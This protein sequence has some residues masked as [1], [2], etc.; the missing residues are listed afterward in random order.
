MTTYVY[1]FVGLAALFLGFG[2]LP[3]EAKKFLFQTYSFHFIFIAVAIWFWTLLPKSPIRKNIRPHLP[4][5][6]L[7]LFLI[8]IIF[9]IS[10][11]HLR[12]LY[13]ETNLLGV[14]QAMLEQHACYIPTQAIF[15]NQN[16]PFIAPEWGIRPFAFPFFLYLIHLINGY[17]L[18]NVYVL[19]A[20]AG[21]FALFLFY[22]L[23]QNFFSKTLSM[24]GMGLLA[25]YP[26]FVLW[27]TS[28]GFE[29][30]NLTLALL[31]F[32]QLYHLLT[33][34]KPY[35]ATR[36]F[37]TLVLLAQMRYEAA[38]FLLAILPFAIYHTIKHP[39]SRPHTIIIITPL[40]LLP[41][42]WQRTL[43]SGDYAF[44]VTEGETMFGLHHF[45]TNLQHAYSFFSGTQSEYGTLPFLFYLTL[46]GILIG[47]IHLIQNRTHITHTTHLMILIASLACV[48]Q[49]G[50]ILGYILG[51]LTRPFS[52][53]LGI[54]FLPFLITPIIY[55]CHLITNKK[56]IFI[57]PILLATSIIIFFSW[58]QRLSTASVHNLQLN[59]INRAYIGFFQEQDPQ[60]QALIIS[61]YARLF[62]PDQRSAVTFQYANQFWT[63]I[64]HN[65]ENGMF[66]KIFIC[67]IA[68]AQTHTQHK[69]THLTNPLPLK[70]FG[71]LQ[72]GNELHRISQIII[73][74]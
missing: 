29:I 41:V 4:A 27:T 46:A 63:N 18:S 52:I 55:L 13:D 43:Y 62:V 60:K 59:Q 12:I 14:S 61:P 35:H 17:A 9:I 31:A 24:V 7:A 3:I 33:S 48:F 69:D 1:G 54:I 16:N 37:F 67:Q 39:P 28:G 56:S 47:V 6:C 74:K 58:S 64:T 2:P 34:Q 68:D 32:Y 65:L 70:P 40:L 30:A 22:L 71:E 53:R 21:F 42:A 23:L 66:N 51:N 26:I 20:I 72:I 10:P 50:A 8:T 11:T 5:L 19:N 45:I 44:M 25:A 57:V 49:A 73:T 36:L 38:L 15:E